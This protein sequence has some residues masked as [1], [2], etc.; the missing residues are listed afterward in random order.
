M[1]HR[2]TIQ[3]L[4]NSIPNSDRF[5]DTD[6]DLALN[7][8]VN[9]YHSYHVVPNVASPR[10]LKISCPEFVTRVYKF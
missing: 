10:P 1:A 5:V 9:D 3:E 2:C 4:Y 8:Q 7:I 6:S